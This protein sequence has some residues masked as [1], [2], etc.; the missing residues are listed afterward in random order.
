[1]EITAISE[2]HGAVIN[3]IFDATESQLENLRK[4]SSKF[5]HKVRVIVHPFYEVE[6]KS[7]MK[8]SAVIRLLKSDSDQRLP[9]LIFEESDKCSLYTQSSNTLENQKGA[10]IY[11]VPTVIGAPH[12]TGGWE[13][14]EDILK[15]AGIKN[16]LIGG[17]YLT[18]QDEMDGVADYQSHFKNVLERQGYN[19][20]SSLAGCVG[21][22]AGIFSKSD[23]NIQLSNI[24]YPLNPIS[25]K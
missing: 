23:F 1:M 18:Y 21:I 22:V 7:N 13:K 24:S 9:I 5:G 25:F 3:N 10:G 2:I 8:T 15:K 14:L 16:M 12:P 4:E 17:R 6:D 11:L 20:P 19:P